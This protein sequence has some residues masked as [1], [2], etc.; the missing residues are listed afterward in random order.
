M[1]KIQS[2]MLPITLIFVFCTSF[3]FAVFAAPQVAEAAV[4]YTVLSIP[5]LSSNT[6]A[7]IGETGAQALGSILI[8]ID[9]AAAIKAGDILSIS[10]PSEINLTNTATGAS[11]ELSRT[12]ATAIDTAW[13]TVA[14]HEYAGTV[15]VILPANVGSAANALIIPPVA[16][17]TTATDI[18]SSAVVSSNKTTLDITFNATGAAN[19]GRI[20]V[21][22][23]GVRVGSIEGDIGA[24]L[25]SPAGSAFPM[26]ILT[27]AKVFQPGDIIIAIKSVKRIGGSSGSIDTISIIE[28]TRGLF[29]PGTIIDFVLPNGFEW[30]KEAINNNSI[31]VIGS[32]GLAGTGNAGAAINLPGS[33]NNEWYMVL[34]PTAT[35]LRLT[36]SDSYNQTKNSGSG[37]INIGNETNN[38]YAK[39][40]HLNQV[41]PVDVTVLVNSPN[42]EY[43][44]EQYITVAQFVE[45]ELIN[46]DL[47]DLQVSGLTVS[48]F[49]PNILKYC[50]DVPFTTLDIPVVTATT[51]NPNALIT[52]YQARDLDGTE[53]E[54]TAIVM[55]QSQDQT[56]AETYKVV[57]TR[58]NANQPPETSDCFIATA[59]FGSYLDP[60]V[61]ILRE[62]RD[63]IL[64][65]SS[66]GTYFVNQ[67]YTYSLP[68]A[69][70]IAQYSFLKAIVRLIL[71]P[72]IF[73][74][75]YPES[76]IF[77]LLI[78]AVCILKKHTIKLQND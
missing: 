65:S 71:T 33:I 56:V 37:R 50:V 38:A 7:V 70:V 5:I 47:S 73:A 46:T 54:R 22:F 27:V 78:V 32:W 12:T 36:F 26:G 41:R 53:S 16:P 31:S 67:Y 58:S 13:T 35:T 11:E 19:A 45:E 4:T 74:I 72:I 21:T 2:K 75:Q 61:H 15:G 64:L 76:L 14:T 23:A 39:I 59:V 1:L 25:A 68:I 6:P 66:V 9:N 48:G 51:A 77:V 43:V 29:S 49:S 69:E 28:E 44:K 8:D 10:F 24:T 18:I 52:I 60:H 42:N 57:F 34:R 55:V 20:L 62:F 63:N 40:R 3:I 30:D 17:A